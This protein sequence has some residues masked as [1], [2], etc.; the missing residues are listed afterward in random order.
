MASKPTKSEDIQEN[1]EIIN[2]VLAQ[3]QKEFGE[4]A[5]MRLGDAKARVAVACIST[6]SFSLDQIGRA[7]V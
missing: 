4:G 1:R 3:I 5:I 2:T 7:H 6:G